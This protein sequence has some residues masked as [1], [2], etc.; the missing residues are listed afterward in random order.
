MASRGKAPP[1]EKRLHPTVAGL[2]YFFSGKIELIY[3]L[4]I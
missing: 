2:N 1:S 3:R 4:E